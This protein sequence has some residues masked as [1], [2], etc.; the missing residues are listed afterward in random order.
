MEDL[1][2]EVQEDLEAETLGLLDSDPEHQVQEEIPP[3][4]VSVLGQVMETTEEA[5]ILVQEDLAEDKFY[6]KIKKVQKFITISR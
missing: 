6:W 1:A 2:E 3:D 5:L 4:P